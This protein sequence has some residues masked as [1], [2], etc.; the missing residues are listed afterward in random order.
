MCLLIISLRIYIYFCNK[1]AL[2]AC[3]K[4][5]R[6]GYWIPGVMSDSPQYDTAGRL[7]PRGML[8]RGD[9]LPNKSY[10]WE[11]YSTQYDTA[12][13][14]CKQIYSRGEIDSA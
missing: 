2:K 9:R 6:N 5:L 13:N 14:F 3:A 7:T 8:L 4:V 12:G 10:C 1:H 11:T